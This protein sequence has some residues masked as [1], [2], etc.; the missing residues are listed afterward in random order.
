MFDYAEHDL[1]EIIKY[2]REQQN[3]PSEASIKSLLWQV[4]FKLKSGP[5]LGPYLVLVI[6]GVMFRL[7][8]QRER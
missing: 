3:A 7:Y 4:V 6:F 1:Y 5:R 8:P 2:H